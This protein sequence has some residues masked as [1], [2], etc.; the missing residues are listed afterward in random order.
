MALTELHS[1]ELEHLEQLAAEGLVLAGDEAHAL[2]GFS[3]VKERKAHLMAKRALW[4]AGGLVV[5]MSAVWL[6]NTFQSP[7]TGVKASGRKYH[8][9]LSL[10]AIPQ[11]QRNELPSR[12]E[13]KP[14]AQRL[15][16]PEEPAIAMEEVSVL[17]KK[18]ATPLQKFTEKG[19]VK[20]SINF[21]EYDI[22]WMN[23]FKVYVQEQ[24]SNGHEFP[25]STAPWKENA[26]DADSIISMAMPD[27]HY[28]Q[29][30]RAF[31]HLEQSQFAQ[32]VTIF[33][34]LLETY[35]SD[36]NLRFYAGFAH[37]KLGNQA[38]AIAQ[39]RELQSI[40]SFVFAEERLFYQGIAH[41][42]SNEIES[43][44]TLLLMLTKGKGSYAERARCV[45]AQGLSACGE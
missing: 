31:Q 3:A 25:E 9:T 15:E 24:L 36:V 26:D 12:A 4:I 39:F 27:I 13:H 18:E 42:Q 28:Q 29:L 6:I 19:L 5:F 14:L 45:L 2:P 33:S 44:Q 41:L 21:R 35:P 38:L 20:A 10:R 17:D 43:G 37:L 40:D 30:L 7:A 8:E 16:I 34:A 32:A 23:H 11:A 22:R 1:A